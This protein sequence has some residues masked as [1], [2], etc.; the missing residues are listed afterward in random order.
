MFLPY[1]SK[2]YSMGVQKVTENNQITLP[3]A[4]RKKL[5]VKEGDYVEIVYKNGEIRIRRFQSDRK[6]IVL[7]KKMNLTPE[8]I[9]KLITKDMRECMQ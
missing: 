3:A 6:V 5:S 8:E 4:I 1:H 9:D 2:G 7:G